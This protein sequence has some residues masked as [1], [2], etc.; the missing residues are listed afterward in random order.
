MGISGGSPSPGRLMSTAMKYRFETFTL[1]TALF[2][3]RQGEKTVHVEPLV[4]DLLHCLVSRA[5]EVLTREQIIARVWD[6]RFVSDATVSSAIKAA[7]RALGDDGER[8]A[9][10][11]T[12]RGRGFQFTAVVEEIPPAS[13]AQVS[14]QAPL[15]P[16][17]PRIAGTATPDTADSASQSVAHPGQTSSLAASLRIAVLPLFPLSNE[18]E[19]QIFGDAISQEIILE[20]SRLHWLS[21]IARGSSF[22]F[23]GQEIDLVDAQKRLSADYFVTGTILGSGD[24]CMLTVELCHAKSGNVLWADS[25][26]AKS[27]ELMH[28]RS[29]LAG[30]IVATL[31]PRIQANEAAASVHVPTEQL[32]AWAAYHRGL[33][34][35]YHL[36][37][38]R[39][40]E[41]AKLFRH[42]ISL[43]PMFARAHAGLS[44][45]HFHKA[46]VREDGDID[47]QVQ[48]TRRHA[49][50]AMEL[51]PLDPFVNL[52]F[53]RSKWIAGDLEGGLVWMERASAISPNFVFALYNRALIGT[54]LGEGSA[55]ETRIIQAI[56]LSPIDPLSYAMLA[57]RALTYVVRSDFETA[58][59][60]A[61]QAARAPHAHVQIF[62]IGA[63]TNELAGNRARADAHV[64]ELRRR[65]PHFVAADFLRSFPLPPGPIRTRVEKSLGRLGL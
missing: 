64:A 43:D 31:E 45:S 26:A 16:P 24:R 12:V 62:A 10:I 8:Q 25:F 28:L 52:S 57:T 40:D 42:A 59:A 18:P 21:V 46:L 23:R 49:E 11:R 41:A 15:K 55:N 53:G 3:L 1:D 6:G 9:F 47:D 30:Q 34:H 4:F 29:S 38:R 35:M 14:A 48:E 56:D 17:E 7:R 63:F 65:R 32:D 20:L 44:F 2:E 54:L 36:S 27:E 39:S 13:G 60:W 22:Q 51:D 50:R 58:C 19:L 33:W 5:G 37:E 61:D